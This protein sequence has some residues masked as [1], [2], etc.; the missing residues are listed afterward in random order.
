MGW[1]ERH[2]AKNS[3][4][5]SQF[6]WLTREYCMP[7]YTQIFSNQPPN[8]Q[9]FDKGQQT[10]EI[11]SAGSFCNA[12][13]QQKLWKTTWETY[14]QVYP[15]LP[16]PGLPRAPQLASVEQTSGSALP[17][18]RLKHIKTGLKMKMQHSLS[19]YLSK[20]PN[21]N[22]LYQAVK[23]THTKIVYHPSTLELFEKRIKPKNC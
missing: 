14:L 22:N 18:K 19:W 21:H 11:I 6:L 1:C 4:S 10:I 7:G 15:P 23:W 2:L 16:Q 12:K 20:A 3:G 9:L 8:Y 5:E 17:G 13:V